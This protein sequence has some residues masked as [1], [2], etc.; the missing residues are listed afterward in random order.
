MFPFPMRRPLFTSATAALVACAAFAACSSGSTPN[1]STAV[2][3][4]RRVRPTRSEM[5]PD[6]AEP[7]SYAI[8]FNRYTVA[9]GKTRRL[10][11]RV[12][13]P[14]D[15]VIEG[16]GQR[17]RLGFTVESQSQTTPQVVLLRPLADDARPRVFPPST[18]SR[19]VRQVAGRACQLFVVSDAR[20]CVDN[21]GLV[22]ASDDGHTADVATKVTVED[23]ARSGPSIAS[24]L[25]VGYSSPDAGSVRP[26]AP[27]S[28]PPGATDYALA[29]PPDGFAFVGRYAVVALSDEL[30]KRSSRKVAAGVADVYVRGPDA[31]VIDRGGKLDTSDVTEDDLGS[32]SGAQPVDLGSLGAGQTGIAG[33]GPFG[34]REVRVTPS[35][36]RYVVVSGTL[37]IDQLV[38]IAKSLRA[39]PG[40][41]LVYTDKR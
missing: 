10:V 38:A 28:S 37:P 8:A 15:E 39:T 25:A 41:E 4:D 29:A 18:R 27:S 2:V 36:G 20:Y 1:S 12:T 22:L 7:G 32:L 35:K 23:A 17:H 16:N 9:T 34:Y 24:E 11:R 33:D 13:R 6:V 21:A 40:T 5:P 19:G 26:I 31:V 3:F 30:L 14:F